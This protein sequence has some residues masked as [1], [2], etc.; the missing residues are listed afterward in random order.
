M[1]VSRPARWLPGRRCGCPVGEVGSSGVGG[2]TSMPGPLHGLRVL[3]CS[4]GPAGLRAAGLLAD[5]GAD[6]IWVERPGGHRLR[7]DDPVAAAVFNRGKRSIEL[8]LG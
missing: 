6:V 3:D 4:T 7:R 8:D 2:E 5:Y 1:L